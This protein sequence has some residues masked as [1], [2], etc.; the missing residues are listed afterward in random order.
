[1]APLFPARNLFWETTRAAR[2][3][4]PNQMKIPEDKDLEP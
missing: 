3:K 4:K 1:M 2:S